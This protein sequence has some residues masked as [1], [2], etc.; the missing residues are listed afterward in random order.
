MRGYNPGH[1]GPED[2]PF[3]TTIDAGCGFG[4]PLYAVCFLP[5]GDVDDLI[6]S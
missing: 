4:G 2:G 1:G 6:E 5:D 3:S